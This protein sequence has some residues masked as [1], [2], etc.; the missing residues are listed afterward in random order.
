M[1]NIIS[2]AVG[3]VESAGKAVYRAGQSVG[4][5]VRSIGSE[6]R[7][8]EVG[9]LN[10]VESHAAPLRVHARGSENASGNRSDTSPTANRV[11]SAPNT[12]DEMH[13]NIHGA[14]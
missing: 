11:V 13:K 4:A 10:Q 14:K 12:G 1:G 9:D 2:D 7:G 6:A 5:D 3:A 8:L